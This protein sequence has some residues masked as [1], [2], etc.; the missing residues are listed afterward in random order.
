[1]RRST[2][3]VRA[4]SRVTSPVA[5]ACTSPH[6][7]T[8]STFSRY[9]SERPCRNKESWGLARLRKWRL[10]QFPPTNKPHHF[11]SVAKKVHSSSPSS[12]HKASKANEQEPQQIL[13]ATFLNDGGAS[14]ICVPTTHYLTDLRALAKSSSTIADAQGNLSHATH[15]G[16]L[17]LHVF[18]N[19]INQ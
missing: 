8:S 10:R 18:R 11:I 3:D 17:I 4:R 19:K 5:T 9:C 16:T 6:R 12:S 7:T 2:K 13:H 14:Q 15:E 1:M